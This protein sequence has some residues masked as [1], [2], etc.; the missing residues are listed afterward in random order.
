MGLKNFFEEALANINPF[1]NGAT[2]STV[3]AARKKPAPAVT[4]PANTTITPRPTQI[5]Q[6]AAVTQPKVA[7]VVI[8]KMQTQDFSVQP[9]FNDNEYFSKFNASDVDTQRKMREAA[10]AQADNTAVV[11]KNDLDKVTA[12]KSALDIIDNHGT[13][14]AG[15]FGTFL[16]DT[17]KSFVDSFTQPTKVLGQGIDQAINGPQRSQDEIKSVSQA[18]ATANA[19]ATSPRST[20]QQVDQARKN[21]ADAQSVLDYHLNHAIDITD[22]VRQAGAFVQ[23]ASNIPIAGPT[24]ALLTTGAKTAGKDLVE[25]A[26]RNGIEGAAA[27]GVNSGAGVLTDQ[28]SQANPLDVIKAGATGAVVGGLTGAATPIVGAG[29]SKLAQTARTA[30]HDAILSKI[31]D[32]GGQSSGV[33]QSVLNTDAVDAIPT[34]GRAVD[35]Y[36][37]ELFKGNDIGEVHTTRDA[38][39][40]SIPLTQ[41]S[42]NKL[43]AYRSVYNDTS[44]PEGA[45][46]PLTYI[47]VKEVQ[48]GFIIR[49]L[50]LHS[51][52]MQAGNV[53]GENFDDLLKKAAS[54]GAP[55]PAPKS[56]LAA[57]AQQAQQPSPDP[58]A[59][60][61]AAA[62]IAR[63]NQP[64]PFPEPASTVRDIA[65]IPT[66]KE[67]PTA[68]FTQPEAGQT[69]VKLNTNRLDIPEE[70]KPQ[71]DAETSEII[72]KLTNKDV[73]EF[74]KGA[75]IDYKSYGEAGT[76]KKIAEQLNLRSQAAEIT[77]AAEE[78]RKAGDLDK[79]SQL[80]AQAAELGRTSRAQGS[81]IARQLQARRIIADQMNTPQQKVFR[82]LD[83][84]GVDPEVYTK[85]LA[86]VD[87]ADAGQVADAYRE[88]VPAKFKD[89]LDKYR[90]TNM[91]SSPLTHIVNITSNLQGSFG[92]AP[93][94]KAV[95]GGIDAVHSAVTG[96]DRTRFA[97][98]AGSYMKGAF[99]SVPEAVQTFKDIMTG[100][101]TSEMVDTNA[102]TNGRL[103]TS[104]VLGKLDTTL[105]FV[106]KL[107]EASDRL[108][109]TIA[110]GGE[111]RSLEFRKSR[112]GVVP[113]DMAGFAEDA[114]SYTNF[115][116]ELGKEG[117]GAVLDAID[118]IP[119]AINKLRNHKNPIVST[120]A[121]FTIPFV[122]TPT[123]LLKQG[124]EY[125]PAGLATLWK[126]GDKT[127]QL[128]KVAVGTS[129]MGITAGAFAANDA[130]TFGE[131]TDPDQRNAFRAEGKQ[132]YSVKIGGHWVSYSKLHPAIA[133]NL[134]ATA[135]VKDALDKGSI[136]QSSADKLLNGFAG[137]VNFFVN[138]S[139]MKSVGD[140]VSGLQVKDGATL[141][142][143]VAGV[144]TN[145]A[146]QLVPFKSLVS[147]IG[148]QID[149]TQRKPDTQAPTIQQI[150]QSLIQDIP[151]LNSSVPARK[152][153]YD[154]SDLKNDNPILNAFSPVKVTN[155]KGFGNTTGLNVEDRMI[156]QQLDPN[157]KEQFRQGV[158][159]QKFAD[160]QALAEENKIKA[161]DNNGSTTSGA[162]PA[163]VK[164]AVA[165]AGPTTDS[166]SAKTAS[167]TPVRQLSN[168]KF[169]AK[170]GDQYKTFDSESKAQKAVSDNDNQKAVDTFTNSNDKIKEIGDK[171]YYKTG[172]GEVK[173]KDTFTYQADKADSTIKLNL[174][175]AKANDDYSGWKSAAEQKYQLIQAKIARLDPD[176]QQ[177]DINSLTLDAENLISEFQ[178]YA[179]Y[180]G[181][182]KA[183]SGNSSNKSS[184]GLDYT[185]INAYGDPSSAGTT[186]RSIL[187]NAKITGKSAKA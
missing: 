184:N 79:S 43:A 85:R 21:A 14:K 62:N 123:N 58:I 155:D 45:Q 22:P 60:G 54:E 20:P 108:G 124:L 83:E 132:A 160:K 158:I 4:P 146:N 36:A 78:A 3:A 35:Q 149:N 153:P 114:A 7:P 75:G 32:A 113:K 80:L 119:Q 15:N 67:Q 91:L 82:L 64:S 72:N 115:R 139:Y 90:Y 10:Q 16:A 121:K 111:L 73:Q 92:I 49:A 68:L 17:G 117:Q 186:F 88:L 5:S 161:A 12:A 163:D 56:K 183:K 128:A 104:G 50:D 39:G 103:A 102:I 2:A 23:A 70:M 87:F 145:Y 187:K 86:G 76:K 179:G 131:P 96:A 156:Q 33:H 84:A 170:I 27:G 182:S 164:A 29:A 110:K 52:N 151:G 150:G 180:G 147:W 46:H 116:Q 122:T 133:F 28:G 71:L 112:G 11:N 97:G 181:L 172:T 8:P 159:D 144:A 51:A 44:A 169:Y 167:S 38:E 118:S 175:R 93:L 9:G 53:N 143:T 135:A 40:N 106:P 59:P 13:K 55:Q 157:G 120:F 107:L 30:S 37:N 178:K 25:S 81:D 166:S 126:N 101:K 74:A 47:P 129:V 61:E 174:D 134:A 94:T 152:N 162:I 48:P 66:A 77:N 138:Q 42:A 18:N 105:S 148:R 185:K 137:A 41:D 89:W 31:A 69:K 99:K 6:P 34:S 136:D 65:D 177:D 24:G 63:A 95:A 26:I 142:S 127:G 130:I 1:D 141:Q 154:N 125:S 168:G 109:M 100:K 171:T 57:F 165:A 176:T 98:E 173:S 140:F 19:I